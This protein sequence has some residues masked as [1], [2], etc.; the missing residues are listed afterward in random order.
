MLPGSQQHVQHPGCRSTNITGPYVDQSGVAMTDGGGTMFLGT[1][2]NFIGPGHSSIFT[3]DGAD[4]FGYH[5]YDGTDNGASKYN[6]RQIFW[7]END[8]PSIAPP[9]PAVPGDYNRDDTVDA[10][11]YV[12]WRDT[13]GS[14]FDLRADGTGNLVVDGNDYRVWRA[15][16]GDTSTEDPISSMTTL[17]PEVR[18]WQ[19]V[20]LAILLR[21]PRGN[22]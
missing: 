4:W 12:V 3:D 17:V 15:R 2:G 21:T 8:W 13:L 14:F 9:P 10:S 18:S 19:L 20:L 11:D 16:F 1:Q 6:I 5:Y 22:R 7:H